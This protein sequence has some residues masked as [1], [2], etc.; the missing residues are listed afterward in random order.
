MT[1]R[2]LSAL[3]A[4]A[5]LT[6]SMACSSHY[7]PLPVSSG[8][9]HASLLTLQ[10]LASQR[11]LCRIANPWAPQQTAIQYLLVPAADTAF[12][13]TDQQHIEQQ[14]GPVQLLRT[15]LQRVA[16]TS[17]SH[18]WLLHQ[19]G[20]LSS[21]SVMCDA[22]YV[23]DTTLQQAL[24]A[25]RVAEGGSGMAPNTEVLLTRQCGALWVSPYESAS[26][27]TLHKRFQLP[28]IYCADYMETSPLARA[29]WMRF[30]GLLV[31]HQTE[32]DSLFALVEQRYDSIASL[33]RDTTSQQP[34]LLPELPY[35]GT[36]YVAGGRSSI[37]RI[38]TAAGFRYPWAADTH[39]G[40]LSL[41][42]EAVFLQAQQADV[43]VIK[44]NKPGSNL[45]L[46]Q[47]SA[48]HTLFPQIQALQRGRVFGCNTAHSNYF[49][50]TPFRPDWL[51]EEFAHIAQNNTDS[52]R[53]FTL[54]PPK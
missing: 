44:Y 19:L 43:W 49:D 8:I 53:F 11:T 34:L 23:I 48:Q 39:G 2:I 13:L 46:Q 3:A 28:V 38:Y 33:P 37:G 47:L 14:Y 52:L 40:S 6:L 42:P 16:L 32:A 10:P 25:H 4:I 9:R 5:L 29:E 7:A 15:P 1:Q 22:Q 51:L 30:Y 45:T 21:V 36:W 54:L 24:Q 50:V 26:A 18:A 27:S 41:S 17:S 20:A 31:G 12:T 35:S